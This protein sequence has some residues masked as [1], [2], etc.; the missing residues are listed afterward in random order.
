M[1][2]Y[3]KCLRYTNRIH[4]L[5]SGG[6]RGGILYGAGS[7]RYGV[8]TLRCSSKLYA[9]SSSSS[10]SQ[11][12]KP[13]SAQFLH[14]RAHHKHDDS[15]SLDS[16]DHDHDHD[17]TH[18]VAATDMKATAAT[19]K[20]GAD[21]FKPDPIARI[22][23]EQEVESVVVEAGEDDALDGSGESDSEPS[24]ATS[25]EPVHGQFAKGN[26]DYK[27]F[28]ANPEYQEVFNRYGGNDLLSERSLVDLKPPP[29]PP[30]FPQGT[31]TAIQY[32]DAF[33]LANSMARRDYDFYQNKTGSAE[34]KSKQ[35]SAQRSSVDIEKTFRIVRRQ[36]LFLLLEDL[37]IRV[38]RG[39]NLEQAADVEQ[40][41]NSL[42]NVALSLRDDNNV[43]IGKLKTECRRLLWDLRT[44]L[45]RMDPPES[46]RS[47][48]EEARAGLLDMGLEGKQI[49]SASAVSMAIEE[50]FLRLELRS[51]LVLENE[52]YRVIQEQMLHGDPNKLNHMDHTSQAD[53]DQAYEVLNAMRTAASR[54]TVDE[55]RVRGKKT[56]LREVQRLESYFCGENSCPLEVQQAL[57]KLRTVVVQA[58]Q[59]DH[60]HQRKPSGEAMLL[61][62]RMSDIPN[63]ER[64]TEKLLRGGQPST[65]GIEWLNSYGVKAAVDLRG[66]DRH[67]SWLPPSSWGSIRCFNIAIEDF[68]APTFEQVT[69]FINIVN[70]PAN[71]P[72][73]VHCKAG[74]G[75]TGTIIACWRVSRGLTVDES[76]KMERLY[77]VDGG[78][79]R[80]EAFIRKFAMLWN[81]QY[82]DK[83]SEEEDK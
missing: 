37:V 18:K 52:A 2:R 34:G 56:L 38:R 21:E 68:E 8:S 57:E 73:F 46:I 59:S 29:P 58:L 20:K 16:H 51:L 4:N 69:D 25:Q 61:R 79:L 22:V 63:F 9:S 17:H 33:L 40:I 28:T 81:L 55:H 5:I 78:G 62:P 3:T 10:S 64:V 14:Q 26:I 23:I 1:Y 75:R 60:A 50:S 54:M 27:R 77:S 45:D 11:D 66:S 48:M 43:D 49:H 31:L 7:V 35:N 41:L 24:L 12:Y 70:D 65:R 80:Q 19:S 36:T 39:I 82:G 15:G 30:S 13:G 76:L 44:R 6:G 72:V 32:A 42:E 67:N 83:K 47:C 74:I 71:C 53:R